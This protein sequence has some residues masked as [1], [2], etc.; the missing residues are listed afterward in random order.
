MISSTICSRKDLDEHN[1]S[2]VNVSLTCAGTE[3]GLA[4]PASFIAWNTWRPRKRMTCLAVN[5]RVSSRSGSTVVQFFTRLYHCLSAP[6]SVSLSNCVFIH[7]SAAVSGSDCRVRVL[8]VRIDMTAK[9]WVTRDEKKPSLAAAEVVGLKEARY[10]SCAGVLKAE[11]A[12]PVSRQVSACC[13][14]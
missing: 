1:A 14:Q 12:S 6:H 10:A 2:H 7:A 13:L 11:G 8:P 9:D 3:L 5:S 4:E